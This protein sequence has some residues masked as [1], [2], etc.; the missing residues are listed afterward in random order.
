MKSRSIVAMFALTTAGFHA[1]AD[2]EITPAHVLDARD[3][4]TPPIERPEHVFPSHV[5][6]IAGMLQDELARLEASL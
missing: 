6:R 4:E 1:S 5:Y 3:V 2:D